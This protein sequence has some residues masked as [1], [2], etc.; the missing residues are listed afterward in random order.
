[1]RIWSITSNI[2][3]F[4][5]QGKIRIIMISEF[6]GML[7]RA[8]RNWVVMN[9]ASSHLRE[10]RNAEEAVSL[11]CDQQPDIILIDGGMHR[12]KDL[13]TIRCIKRALPHSRLEIL[14]MYENGE[15]QS[16]AMAAGADICL[17]KSKIR[18]EPFPVLTDFLCA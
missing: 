16:A 5:D 17:V 13:E 15:Y 11:V 3:Y 9:F 14:T 10:A 7:R 18:N 1:M 8:L 4:C 2:N 12:M 6:H